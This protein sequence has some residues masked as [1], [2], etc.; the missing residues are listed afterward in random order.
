MW[1]GLLALL[2]LFLSQGE[3]LGQG[4]PKI[5]VFPSTFDFGTVGRLKGVVSRSLLIKN[6][7]DAPLVIVKVQPN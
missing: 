1:L 5:L 7:G 3:A 2:I 4:K 6:G